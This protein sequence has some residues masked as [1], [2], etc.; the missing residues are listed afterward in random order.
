MIRAV[1]KYYVSHYLNY[2][3]T[4]AV[5]SNLIMSLTGLI[6]DIFSI[7]FVIFLAD[8]NWWKSFDEQ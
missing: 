5:L 3:I 8:W 1:P 2:T 4:I 6:P 7:S